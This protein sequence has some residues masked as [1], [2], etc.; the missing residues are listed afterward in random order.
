MVASFVVG[1][2]HNGGVRILVSLGPETEHDQNGIFWVWL[3]IKL[4]LENN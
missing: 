4:P 1:C 2:N 3:V